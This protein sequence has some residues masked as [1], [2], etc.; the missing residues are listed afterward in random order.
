MTTDANDPFVRVRGASEHNLKTSTSTSR[1]T[2]WS[3]SPGSP[4]RASPRSPSA[5][6][7]PRRSGA[8]SS[9][10]RRT[11]AGCCSR[12][13]RRT[14]RRSPGCRP[15]VALQ[16]R[17]GAPELAV[18]R[19]H[20]HHAVEPAADALLPGRHV[21][22]RGRPPGG[23]GLLPQHRRRRLP[24]L[25]RARAWSTT[26]PRTCWSR[27]PSLSIRDGAIAAW[28]GAWQGANLRSIVTGLGIDVDRPWRRLQEEG[29]RLAAVHRRAAVGADQAGAGPDRP[30]L[31]RE[32][33]ERP[34]AR[35]A[36]A[37]RLP[38]RADARAG[39]AVRAERALP[40]LPRQRAAAGGAGGD[41][42]RA[43]DRR[44]QRAVARPRWWRCC[45]RS[46][47]WPTRRDVGADGR[48]T[49]AA[50]RLSADLV[51]RVEV[52]LDL[53]L[54]YLGLG[55]SST[56]LSPGE[57]QRLRI[58]TQLRS[59]L[60]GVVYVLDEP[61]AGLHPADAEP[62]LDVLDRLKA[63]GQLAVRRR[64][65][66]GRRTARRLGGRHRPG[67]RRGRRPGALQRSGRRARA[68]RGVGH[69]RATSSVAPS[70][71]ST[72]RASRR[73]GCT[74]AASPGTTCATSRSTCR[75]AC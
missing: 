43:L 31:L 51:A 37:G 38:E 1:A 6:S 13:A 22:R 36:R 74:C 28:P 18:D 70:R 39:A 12:S 16:Q 41:L 8:T 2:R 69:R 29:P 15:A 66:H 24:A 21:S 3:P 61:S 4:A 54:G 42:R 75:C 34:R 59:G 30:R 40:G 47:S 52:L 25:P 53:G 65:R 32:V 11:P 7:T 60:F 55:R 35:H 73:A 46:P 72:A 23:R 57:A 14:S 64:A 48:A 17:R 62:L 49:E 20:H 19:R 10:S 33:L 26:S 63:L 58:A 67:R 71:S 5:R 50:V 68:G 45:G 9:R 27:T 44:G 56:T